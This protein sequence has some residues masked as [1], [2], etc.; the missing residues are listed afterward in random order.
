MS[1]ERPDIYNM[2]FKLF[3]ETHKYHF[4]L[5]NYELYELGSQLKRSAESV[6]ETITKVTS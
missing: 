1:Y 4:Q 3:I 6:E 2:A 5:P